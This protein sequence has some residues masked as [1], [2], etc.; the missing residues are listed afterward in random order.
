MELDQKVRDAAGR[1]D[2]ALL[3]NPSH[4][5]FARRTGLLPVVMQVT[6][7]YAA[8]P[9]KRRHVTRHIGYLERPGL[10]GYSALAPARVPGC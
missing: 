10:V 1:V 7:S 9:G 2:L 5:G 6:R 4:S 8:S 3:T